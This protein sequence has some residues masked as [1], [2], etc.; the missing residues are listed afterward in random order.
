MG[1]IAAGRALAA[2]RAT[3]RT[4][5]RRVERGKEV[6]WL[7]LLYRDVI[8]VGATTAAAAAACVVIVVVVVV[9]VVRCRLS[10]VA[11]PTTGSLGIFSRRR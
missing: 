9:D 2:R 4:V 1:A 7:L 8:V 10:R 6:A 11:A 3:G 5:I